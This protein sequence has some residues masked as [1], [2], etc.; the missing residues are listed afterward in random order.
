M[1][2]KTM[3]T[4]CGAVAE[5]TDICVR[6]QV[7]RKYSALVRL[8]LQTDKVT[9][10]IPMEW[11]DFRDGYDFYEVKLNLETGLYFYSFDLWDYGKYDEDFQIT[12]YDKDFTTPDWIKGGQIYHI[13]VDRFFRGK[14]TPKRSDIIY[15]ECKDDTPIFAPNEEGKVENRDFFGGNLSG[16]TEKLPYIKSLGTTAIYLSPIFK[17][18]SN[19]KYDTGD[20]LKIDEMFGTE[21]DFKELV[22]KADEMGIKII[23]D[24]VFNHTGDDSLYFNK[25][26]NYDSVGAY[27]SKDSEYRN[28]YLWNDDGSYKSWWGIDVLPC[29]NKDNEEFLDFICDKVIKKWIEAGIYSWRLDVADEL[30]DKLLDRIRK[31]AKEANLEC[32]IIGEVWEDASNKIAYGQRRRYLQGKQLDSVMNY[33]FKNAIIDYV[34]TGNASIIKNTV[35]EV[36]KNYPKQ[37]TDVLMNFLGTHDT[38]RILTVL[39][40]D[41]FP[42]TKEEEAKLEL[43]EEQYELA[44][45]RLKPALVLVMFLPGVPC[46]FYGDEAGTEGGRDPLNRRY[47]PWGKE[48]K[49]ILGYVR[50]LG[51]IRTENEDFKDGDFSLICAEQGVFAFRRRDTAIVVNISDEDVRFDKAY[52]NYITGK[53]GDSIKPYESLVTKLDIHDIF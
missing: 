8:I 32:L 47:F 43:S 21:S 2:L 15:H 34:K 46:I 48:N 36:L 26:G 20:Y 50:T 38:R 16:I 22:E 11:Y 7:K 24:G 23:L 39:G 29:T 25:Y 5:H 35:E 49:E 28:W 53:S 17:A 19:H 37:C 40:C 27:Q 6:V 30:N 52:T 3:R 9:D 4:P 44:V 42:K 10:Y 14:E 13:F 51:K 1:I 18:Y 41:E 45:K 31:S 33:L 12:V